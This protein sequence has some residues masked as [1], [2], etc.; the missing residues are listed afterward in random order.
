MSNNISNKQIQ[1]SLAGQIALKLDA[2][3]G[4][5]DGQISQSVW[6]EYWESNNGEEF[7]GKKENVDKNGLSVQEAFKFIM[8]RIFN[9]AKKQLSKSEDKSWDNDTDKYKEIDN[10]AKDWLNS[11]NKD[12]TTGESKAV[13]DTKTKEVQTPETGNKSL[14]KTAD[15]NK[16]N[17]EKAFNELKTMAGLFEQKYKIPQQNFINELTNTYNSDLKSIQGNSEIKT[18]DFAASLLIQIFKSQL[19]NEKQENIVKNALTEAAEHY[20]NTEGENIWG[21]ECSDLAANPSKISE[22]TQSYLEAS[23]SEKNI[24]LAKEAINNIKNNIDKMNFPKE[25]NTENFKEKLNSYNIEERFD[26]LYQHYRFGL[27]TAEPSKADLTAA[28][29]SDILGMNGDKEDREIQ[30]EIILRKTAIEN[31]MAMYDD[32][33]TLNG[34]S[35]AEMKTRLD[36]HKK[37][38]DRAKDYILKNI[39]NT[40]IGQQFEND[41]D[42][43]LFINCL[44]KVGYDIESEG[45][46]RAEDG[47]FVI[48]TNNKT[49]KNDTE[50][51]VL[52]LHETYHNYSELK[53]R[54]HQKG[55]KTEEAAAEMFALLS[56]SDIIS[57]YPAEQFPQVSHFKDGKNVQ[58]YKTKDDVIND[59]AFKPWLEGYNQT[60][61]GNPEEC[62][63]EAIDVIKIK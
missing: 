14:P 45:A 47:I 43:D 24:S 62:I 3:D 18:A 37:A 41:E 59:S 35:F 57:K 54:H 49:L 28:I 9:A 4:N 20:K 56:A 11:A 42:K 19:P 60:H 53:G 46:G 5:S 36:V 38:V 8:T 52:L 32:S 21:Y 1:S 13:S 2:K 30:S 15:K 44:N 29:I 27:K 22:L 16:A 17:L 61:S 34:V 6:N 63:Q 51:L 12:K 39:D 23:N 58:E 26:T 48:E 31:T 25:V 50:M 33:M 40:K 10:V 7:K 55:E